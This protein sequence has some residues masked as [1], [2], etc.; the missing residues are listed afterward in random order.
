MFSNLPKKYAALTPREQRLIVA[1]L[2][3]G[4]SAGWYTLFYDP[5]MQEQ[6]ELRQQLIDMET[7]LAIQ[8]QTAI[9][10]EIRHAHDPDLSTKNQLLELQAQF[11]RLQEQVQS[12]NKQFVPPAL[13]A[14]A[15]SDLLKQ[16]SQLTLIK[17]ETLPVKQQQLIYQHGL[18]LHFSGSYLA[19]LNYLKSLEA[20]PWNFIWD[21]IDYQVKDYPMAEITLRVHTLSLEKSW[22]NV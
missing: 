12:L 18:V 15:L 10:L 11:Q 7:Q 13:M 19:T 22:L 4:L 16:N 2:L 3:M 17:L 14:K 20:M 9:Q 21:S 6:T 8:Q 5:V 1:T